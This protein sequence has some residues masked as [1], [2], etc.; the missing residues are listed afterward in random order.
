[1]HPERRPNPDPSPESLEAKLRALPQPAVPGGLEARLLVGI[2]AAM[3]IPPPH[4]TLSPWRGEGRVRGRWAVWVGV[5][6]TA[7]AACLL[8]VLTWPGRDA[9]NR[10]ASRGTSR[11]AHP[12]AVPSPG[13]NGP[14][15]QVTR[16]PQ[17]NSTSIAPWGV[18]RRDL[19]EAAMPTF[20]WPLP[21]TPPVKA[22]TSI[23][24]NLLD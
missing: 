7:A 18:A 15:H 8:V 14:R 11:S 21:E 23:P 19:D 6:G 24:P 4:P 22:L 2:P 17:D 16:R 12:G 3:P 10:V 20:T 9:G 5:A 1:M 13:T